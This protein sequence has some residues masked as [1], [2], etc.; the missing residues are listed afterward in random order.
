M[1]EVTW[2][3]HVRWFDGK[4]DFQE[5]MLMLLINILAFVFY[6]SHRIFFFFFTFILIYWNVK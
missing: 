1:Q 2:N 5:L 6:N 4:Y 3:V